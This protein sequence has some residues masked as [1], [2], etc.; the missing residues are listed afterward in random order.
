MSKTSQGITAEALIQEPGHVTLSGPLR[1]GG[2]PARREVGMLGSGTGGETQA[3]D[4]L[5]VKPCAEGWVRRPSSAWLPG[6][7]VHPF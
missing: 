6:L 5:S 7:G 4:A 1:S 2:G 3:L